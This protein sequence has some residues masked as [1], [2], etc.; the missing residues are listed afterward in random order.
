MKTA[1][2]FQFWRTLA[3]IHRGEFDRQKAKTDEPTQM[4]MKYEDFFLFFPQSLLSGI[5]G[6]NKI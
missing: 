3:I 2:G 1:K 6:I 4:Y 5:W